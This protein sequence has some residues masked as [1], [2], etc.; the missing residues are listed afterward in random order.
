MRIA[1]CLSGFIRTWEFTKWSLLNILCRDIEY[2]IF[3]HTYKQNY[4]E[5]SAGQQNVI[6]IQKTRLSKCSRILKM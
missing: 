4:F 6:Y 3:V 2:D 1:I 5:Y